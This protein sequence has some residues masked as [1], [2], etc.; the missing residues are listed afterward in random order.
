MSNDNQA[1]NQ[2]ATRSLPPPHRARSSLW[3]YILGLTG[4]VVWAYYGKIDQV[5]RAQAQV[6]AQERQRVEEFTAMLAKVR[7]QIAHL[8]K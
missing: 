4:L 1:F 6:I 8:D 2:D 5:T 3:V 7:G